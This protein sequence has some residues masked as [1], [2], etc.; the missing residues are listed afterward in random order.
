MDAETIRT[1]QS[2]INS[3]ALALTRTRLRTI[4][5]RTR[6]Y[7]HDP[8]PTYPFRVTA[9]RYIPQHSVEDGLTL[10]LAHANGLHKVRQVVPLSFGSSAHLT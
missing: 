6:T 2:Y 1:L 5:M 8:R 7:V 9:V 10:I 3:L 4:V